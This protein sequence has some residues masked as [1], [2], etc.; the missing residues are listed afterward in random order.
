MTGT[1]KRV[2]E[3]YLEATKATQNDWILLEGAIGDT[4][5]VLMNANGIVLDS[6]ADMAG[7]TLTYDDSADKLVLAGATV[8]TVKIFVRMAEA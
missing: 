2:V 8:G 4:T 3:Y 1:P 5:K 7:E 6:S